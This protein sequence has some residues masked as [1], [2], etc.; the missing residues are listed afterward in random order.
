[1]SDFSVAVGALSNKSVTLFFRGCY[2]V[3]AGRFGVHSFYKIRQRVSTG[4]LTWSFVT[5]ATS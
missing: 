2:Q 4:V 3:F 1:M 5:W